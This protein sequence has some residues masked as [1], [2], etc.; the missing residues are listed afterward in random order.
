MPKVNKAALEIPYFIEI[1][2]NKLDDLVVYNKVKDEAEHD[3]ALVDNKEMTT[4]NF[5][6][7]VSSL[8]NSD[9]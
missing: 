3:K 4:E 1:V 8:V 5:I 6:H 2:T 9:R 7:I